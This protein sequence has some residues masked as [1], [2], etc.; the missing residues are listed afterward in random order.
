MRRMWLAMIVATGCSESSNAESSPAESSNARSSN[1][2]NAS[3][4][5][6]DFAWQDW[7]LVRVE[8]KIRD[9]AFTIELPRELDNHPPEDSEVP[10]WSQHGTV[11]A[12]KFSVQVIRAFPASEAEGVQTY[13]ED[14]ESGII[15]RR[16]EKDRFRVV[17]GSTEKQKGSYYVSAKVVVRRGK[18]VLWCYGSV[19]SPSRRE[20][21]GKWLADVCSTLT[22]MP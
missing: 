8:R 7:Q 12:P 13:A 11:L 14:H 21:E 20:L 9:V 10:S 3:Q 19:T 22:I 17:Y 6:P 15:E 2:E 18:T 5:R 4:R 1:A 16:L